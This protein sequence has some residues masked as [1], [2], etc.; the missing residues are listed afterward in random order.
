MLQFNQER[1]LEPYITLNSNMLKNASNNFQQTYY[2]LMNSSVYGKTIVSKRRQSRVEITRNAERAEKLV[3]KFEFERFKIFGENMAAMCSKPKIITWN[4]PNI[5]GATVLDLSKYYMYRF[6]YQ[7][8]DKTF[9][10]VYFS[11]IQ[12]ASWIKLSVSG[13]S[14]PIC[15]GKKRIQFSSYPEDHALHDNNNKSE[16]LKFKDEFSG[17]YL[18]E[19]ECL[20]PKM[21]SI[22]SKSESI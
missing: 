2:K 10:V 5:V 21:Y 9:N 14:Q 8:M 20:K 16:V 17:D 1:W 15:G 22:T 6:H 18:S 4:T 3:S 19:F 12:T 11:R 13:F 7:V